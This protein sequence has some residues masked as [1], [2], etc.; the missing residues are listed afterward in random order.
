MGR[1]SENPI[2]ASPKEKK[3]ELLL[4]LRKIQIPYGCNVLKSSLDSCPAPARSR[5]FQQQKIGA[6][7]VEWT[8]CQIAAPHKYLKPK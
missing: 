3:K 6:I 4:S 5:V 8:V 2:N 1:I 7:I